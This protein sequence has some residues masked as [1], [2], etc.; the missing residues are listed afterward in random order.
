MKKIPKW[1]LFL[2][3]CSA[4]FLS[5]IDLFIV[6]VALPSIKNGI[7]GTDADMQFVIVMYIIGYASFLITGGKAGE[8]FG[9]KKVFLIGMLV[10][11]VASCLCGFSQSATQLNLARFIQGISAAFMVPQGVAFMPDLFPDAKTTH[12]NVGHLRQH[13]RHC[14]SYWSV[15]RWFNS[16]YCH[17]SRK[18]AVNLFNKCTSR[19]N[20][21][22][23][24]L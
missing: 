13:C 18:L 24:R 10:F 1:F 23:F 6:N 22:H 20:C 9:K 16:G 5:V 8:Y 3:V 14:F 4:I 7:S 17:Y 12:K 21:H 2:I 11:T 15:F 19:I